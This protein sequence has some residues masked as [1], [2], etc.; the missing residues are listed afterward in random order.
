MGLHLS[1]IADP[2]PQGASGSGSES[3]L[4]V[5][6]WI[7]KKEFLPKLTKRPDFKP[8]RK[9]FVKFCTCKDML[10]YLINYFKQYCGSG[11]S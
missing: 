5:R 1:G 8:F 6:I 2:N 10:Y 3:V 4:G 9:T 7:Q 11:A